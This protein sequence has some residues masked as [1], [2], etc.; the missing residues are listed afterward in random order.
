MADIFIFFTK[1]HIK[2]KEARA[3]KKVAKAKAYLEEQG[4]VVCEEG[5]FIDVTDEFELGEEAEFIEVEP[6]EQEEKKKK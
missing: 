2:I 3:A 6:E 5:D 1:T 4:M